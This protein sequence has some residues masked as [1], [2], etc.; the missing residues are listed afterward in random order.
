MEAKFSWPFRGIKSASSEPK[1][2][3]GSG[4]AKSA[5]ACEATVPRG[6][7]G[8]PVQEE[9]GRKPRGLSMFSGKS[10]SGRGHRRSS[11]SLG[12]AQFW[13]AAEGEGKRREEGEAG[14]GALGGIRR[15]CGSL[16]VPEPGARES[17][18]Q[19]SRSASTGAAHERS[20]W[21]VLQKIHSFERIVRQRCSRRGSRREVGPGES[22]ETP[23][24]Q[25]WTD[26]E[27]VKQ[28]PPARP[29]GQPAPSSAEED[30]T[31]EDPPGPEVAGAKMAHG[32]S[33]AGSGQHLPSPL[34]QTPEAEAGGEAA[35]EEG[36]LGQTRAMELTGTSSLLNSWSELDNPLDKITLSPCIKSDDECSLSDESVVTTQSDMCQLD[37][38]Y[39]I[40]LAELRDCGTDCR[41][42]VCKADR[43]THS[44]SLNSNMS[45]MSV[46][47]LIPNDELDRLLAEVKCLDEETVQRVEDVQVVVLH[48]EEGA[49]LGFSIAGG[50]DHENKMVTAHKVFPNGLA[51][52]E[53]TIKQGDEILSING[54]SLKGV[55]HSEAL[56]LLHKARPP[57]QAI[58]VIRK[59]AEVE[60]AALWKG[61]LS[62]QRPHGS[63]DLN[64]VPEGSGELVSVELVTTGTGLGFSL[65]G[66]RS[67]SQGDRPL[68][69]KKVFQGGSADQT[70]L[71]RPGDQLVQVG[72]EDCRSLTCY[73]AWNLIKALP[74]GPLRVVILKAHRREKEQQT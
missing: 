30:P 53:G 7:T 51:A 54:N 21:S 8:G 72:E 41:D 69:I 33:G 63:V 2:T 13:K 16:A 15:R 23:G 65:D 3:S 47:S 55:T 29:G 57:R 32:G 27:T 26:P 18:G 10:G 52:Q 49:G 5:E 48:K 25:V 74:P 39:S 1:V 6:K 42:D 31:G 67:S 22:G 35:K 17:G 37:K 43:L 50:V 61:S 62:D 56:S 34:G 73:E 44:A 20:P 71:I 9:E 24:P 45:F 19:R 38:S 14:P 58:V 59:V 11:S 36:I 64:A 4:P 68:T 28:T 70:G 60:K 12:A 40:S 46:V 66:G